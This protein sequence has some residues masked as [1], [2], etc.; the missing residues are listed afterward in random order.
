[1]LTVMG[2]RGQGRRQWWPLSRILPHK[3]PVHCKTFAFLP[4][5]V[6]L[7][8][9]VYKY[10]KGLFTGKCCSFAYAMVIANHRIITSEKNVLDFSENEMLGNSEKTVSSAWS[11]WKSC[12]KYRR[13]HNSKYHTSL[14]APSA[15]ILATRLQKDNWS[16]SKL[17]QR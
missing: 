8:A 2:F 9:V 16:I 5:L 14:C 12:T 10:M 6:K 1:M 17:F 3:H 4:F 11:S 15:N 13:C 7:Q